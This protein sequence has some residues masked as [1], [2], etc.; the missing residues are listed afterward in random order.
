MLYT[1]QPG[2]LRISA[3]ILRVLRTEERD[4]IVA[5]VREHSGW[6]RDKRG[7]VVRTSTRML[8]HLG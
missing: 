1:L 6:N 5:E 8:A 2:C 3:K 7:D 4:R